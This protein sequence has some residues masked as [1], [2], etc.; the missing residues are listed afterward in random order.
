MK[1]EKEI[2]ECFKAWNTSHGVYSFSKC[3]VEE[4]IRCSPIILKTLAQVFVRFKVRLE[5]RVFLCENLDLP[6]S[7]RKKLMVRM[8][9]CVQ[10]GFY[11]YGDNTPL[12]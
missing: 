8:P 6:G 5:F 3:L 4:K 7:R 12:K 9:T 1:S 10:A 2:V 11:L